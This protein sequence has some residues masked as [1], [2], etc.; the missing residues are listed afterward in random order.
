[1]R[2]AGEPTEADQ[3]CG[4][5]TQ[6][7]APKQRTNTAT[8][9]DRLPMGPR[10]YALDLAECPVSPQTSIP[11]EPQKQNAGLR[12]LLIFAIGT[13]KAGLRQINVRNACGH[14]ARGG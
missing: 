4:G 11:M 5:G 13:I 14:H 10:M 6:Q 3:D 2:F 1:M 7:V 12:N 8:G 9:T